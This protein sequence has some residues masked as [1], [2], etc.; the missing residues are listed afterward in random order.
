MTF[1]KQDVFFFGVLLWE[2]ITHD[3]PYSGLTDMEVILEVARKGG[4]VSHSS[5]LQLVLVCTHSKRA[6]CI[7]FMQR[8]TLH[9]VYCGTALIQTPLGQ[10]K[11]F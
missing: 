1:H 2:L 7:S 6:S 4:L 10:K 9:A 3:V 11:V 5:L 8:Y